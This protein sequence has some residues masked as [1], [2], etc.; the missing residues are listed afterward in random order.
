[1]NGKLSVRIRLDNRRF[2]RF[3]SAVRF[4]VIPEVSALCCLLLGSAEFAGAQ[5]VLGPG[6]DATVLPRHSI[7][8]GTGGG[9]TSWDETYAKDGTLQSAGA[10]FTFDSLGVARVPNLAPLQSN[11][12]TITGIPGFGVT[13]GNSFAKLTN[14][15][16]VVPFSLE[17]GLAPKL[18]MGVEAPYVTT[19]GNAFLNINTA[20]TNG[21]VGFNPAMLTG[22]ATVAAQDLT[23]INEF[24]AAATQLTAAL[25]ACAGSSSTSCSSLNANRAAAQALVNSSTTFTTALSGV[26]VGSRL[27][28]IN[29]TTASLALQGLI[30]SF[31]SSYAA[32]GVSSI[33]GNSP[34]LASV[35]LG[36]SDFQHVLTDSASGIVADPFQTVSRSH[37][38]DVGV[39]GKLLLID[40]FGNSTAARLHPTGANLR[41]SVGGMYQFPTGQADAPNNFLDIGTGRHASSVEG[42]GFL[43]ILLGS[44]FW[45]SGIVRYNH[46]IS[47]TQIVRV[48]DSLGVFAPLSSQGSV[49]RQLGNTIEIET[50]S[51][52]VLNDFVAI[53]GQFLHVHKSQDHYTGTIGISSLP[54]ASCAVPGIVSLDAA[55]LDQNTEATET[56][57]GGGISLSNQVAVQQGHASIPFEVTFLH[58]QTI[59]GSGG[60]QPKYF[61]DRITMR[62]YS[63]LFGSSKSTRP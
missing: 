3:N 35:R 30:N 60:N 49:N 39:S 29:N 33:S 22:G 50:S 1:M 40:T 12:R 2:H 63:K 26:F 53:S 6:D 19:R 58:Q 47:D 34:V 52:L 38:G 31:K 20:G 15:V 23:I 11:L 4:K 9:W 27:V 41:F 28:P 59:S 18:Q 14:R 42:R 8:F 32:F 17:L 57:L 54:C 36:V 61:V 43:D 46:P 37:W 51:R 55:L 16:N 24:T 44:H 62:I 10:R 13:L 21:N 45:Q 56:R 5:R 7:R 25:A 48:T